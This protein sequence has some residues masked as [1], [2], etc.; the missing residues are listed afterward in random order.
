MDLAST[1]DQRSI[2]GRLEE[3]LFDRAII[4]CT[5]SAHDDYCQVLSLMKKPYLCEKPLS[6]NI[7][8]LRRLLKLSIDSGQRNYVV[9]NFDF[10][11]T[12]RLQKSTTF[13]LSYNYYNTGNDGFLWDMCQLI[14][15]SKKNKIFLSVSSDSYKWRF[16]VDKTDVPY[17]EIEESYLQM[18]KAWLDNKDSLLWSV[19]EALEMSQDV[20][21]LQ[22]KLPED[23][24]SFKT[25]YAYLKQ[26]S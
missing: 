15:I 25:N 1:K 10:I 9:N 6:K 12:W 7:E 22:R 4:A 19:E 3:K 2:R 5:T 24:N 11:K 8:S 20:I 14:H 13:E 18:I 21:D 26:A 23:I 16:S 17:I